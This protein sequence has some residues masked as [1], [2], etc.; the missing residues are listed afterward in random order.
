MEL[1]SFFDGVLLHIAVKE[2]PVPV[3]GVI[4][5]IGQ[6]GED[7]KAAIAAA[8]GNGSSKQEAPAEEETKTAAPTETPAH[9]SAQESNA[10]SNGD[11]RIKASPLARSMASDAGIDLA[12]VAG[13]GEQGRIIKRDIEAAL[14]TKPAAP[15]SAPAPAAPAAPAGTSSNCQRG[16]SSTGLWFQ[17]RR[18]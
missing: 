1:D 3:N 10:S 6:E 16:T 9:A 14:E 17:R 15:A 5:V 12:K 13:S 18:E 7:W 4:A 8:G 11:Q 2:G